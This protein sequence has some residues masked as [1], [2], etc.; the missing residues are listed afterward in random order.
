MFVFLTWGTGFGNFES[1]VLWRVKFFHAVSKNY[2]G[3]CQS[4]VYHQHAFISTITY[5][6]CTAELIMSECFMYLFT[7][8]ENNNN[9]LSNF[10]MVVQIFV[11]LWSIYLILI[12]YLNYGEFCPQIFFKQA[13]SYS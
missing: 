6:E 2:I 10:K 4:W 8:I 11:I 9:I 13:Q 1:D 7:K 3:I 12:F 5:L